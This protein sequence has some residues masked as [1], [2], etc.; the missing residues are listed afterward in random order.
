LASTHSSRVARRDRFS[1]AKL[2]AR[3]PAAR[4]NP[5][6]DFARGLGRLARRTVSTRG[7]RVEFARR[8][9][10]ELKLQKTLDRKYSR[11]DYLGMT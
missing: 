10:R 9:G 1:L 8:A 4:V 11:S 3:L 7:S 6:R 5:V 2:E